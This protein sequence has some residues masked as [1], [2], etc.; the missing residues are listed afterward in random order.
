MTIHGKSI[1]HRSFGC[2]LCAMPA[3][4]VFKIHVI[5]MIKQFRSWAFGEKIS[6]I[7]QSSY[8]IGRYTK[9][10]AIM[11]DY[12]S[13]YKSHLLHLNLHA[14]S[15]AYTLFEITDIMHLSSQKFQ[16]SF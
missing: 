2:Q 7:L 16:I 5:I 15:H 14:P 11:N 8:N 9:F 12:T 13:D 10:I 4:H 1:Y 3:V 6:L